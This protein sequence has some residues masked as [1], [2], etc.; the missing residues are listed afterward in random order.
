MSV[1]FEKMMYVLF[2]THKEEL[3]EPYGVFDSKEDAKMYAKLCKLKQFQIIEIRKN[4]SLDDVGEIFA[5]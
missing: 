1:R 4:P 5:G 3:T 2:E